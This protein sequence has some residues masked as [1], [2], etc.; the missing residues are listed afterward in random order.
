[1]GNDII[2]AMD[3]N[4]DDSNDKGLKYFNNYNLQKLYYLRQK[5]IADNNFI[6][7]IN[8]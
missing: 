8:N 6:T 5:T 3:D 7:Y 2:I 4:L 1:M